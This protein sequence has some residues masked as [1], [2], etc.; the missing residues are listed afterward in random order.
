MTIKA[1]F[2]LLTLVALGA[3]TGCA[4]APRW[5]PCPNGLT[6]DIHATR[7]RYDGSDLAK[8]LGGETDGFD[9]NYEAIEFGGAL[10]SSLGVE[11]SRCPTWGGKVER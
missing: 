4:T 5:V 11:P 2:V 8:A 6:L 10:H 9:S 7:G 1:P 3:S